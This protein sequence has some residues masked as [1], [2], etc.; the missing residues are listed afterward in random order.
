VKGALEKIMLMFWLICGYEN[1][2]L[3]K[4]QKT[5]RVTRGYDGEDLEGLGHRY[6]IQLFG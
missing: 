2:D 1:A 4:A 6:R 3:I 5:V